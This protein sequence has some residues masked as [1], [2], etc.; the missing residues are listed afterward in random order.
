M[1][2]T[3]DTDTT[4]SA[5]AQILDTVDRFIRERV[6]PRAQ[7]IDADNVYPQ[8]LHDEAAALGLFALAVPE[9]YGGLGV[10]LRTRLKVIERLARS[11]GTFAVIVCTVPDGLDP[12][13]AHGSDE[14]KQKYL[15]GVASGELMP[16]IALSEPSGGSDVAAMKTTARRDG[17]SYVINGD[18]TWCTHGSFADFITVFAKT[19]ESAGHR[20]ITA[21][22][23][24][25]DTPGFEVVRD[26]DLAC[27]RGS[28]QSTLRFT[29]MRIDQSLRLGDEGE[30]FRM[31]MLAMDDARLNCSAQALGIAYRCIYEATEY[32]KQRV[33]FDRPIIE[34]Q[35]VHFL[36]AE[37]CTEYSAARALWLQAIDDFEA[38]PT[39]QSGVIGSMAKNACTAIGMKAPVEAIQILGAAGLS[40]DL[41]LERMM[42]DSKAYQ[43]FD[44]TTQ[45]HNWII[46]RHLQRE[47]LPFD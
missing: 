46:G 7:A 25:K 47:G 32:A 4:S 41:P 3:A 19:D 20:G 38:G 15:P 44:G 1:N 31:A 37:L 29:D 30:G 45:I 36:L 42:R 21:F 5:D 39:R 35:G 6:E 14:L 27:L 28:P 43:I 26:E 8:D 40:T 23:V 24:P 13:R 17:Q 9:A 11:S 10:G 2:F 16:A 34:F 33:A 18:K 12:L 22:L